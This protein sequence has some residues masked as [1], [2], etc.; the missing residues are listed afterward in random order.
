MAIVTSRKKLVRKTEVT[1]Q[2]GI[3]TVD[4]SSICRLV[5]AGADSGAAGVQGHA[6]FGQVRKRVWDME[7]VN[8]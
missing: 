5:E 8:V 4:I 6:S 7:R 3:A 2:L 1:I